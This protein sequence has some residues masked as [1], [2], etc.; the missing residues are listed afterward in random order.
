MDVLL[1][2]EQGIEER[3]L[4]HFQAVGAV[5]FLAEIGERGVALD[6]LFGEQADGA[7]AKFDVARLVLHS[8]DEFGEVGFEAVE[9]GGGFDIEP[10]DVGG[11]LDLGERGS[12][13]GLAFGEDLPLVLEQVADGGGE[14]REGE[15]P[16]AFAGDRILAGLEAEAAEENAAG[17]V[18]RLIEDDDFGGIFGHGEV[19]VVIG[20]FGLAVAVVVEEREHAFGG[21]AM[22]VEFQA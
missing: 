22:G 17:F 4:R 21:G 16:D 3:G 13:D 20:R 6:P 11:D 5:D 18:E 2:I 9:V 19:D 10:V 15:V 7:V 8:R 1:L 12:A 14:A